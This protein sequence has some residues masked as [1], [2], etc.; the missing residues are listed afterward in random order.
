MSEPLTVSCC[1]SSVPDTQ[2]SWPK[3]GRV[4]M[5]TMLHSL[6]FEL[7]MVI[8]LGDNAVDTN[9]LKRVSLLALDHYLQ[10]CAVQLSGGPR[11]GRRGWV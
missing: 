8:L 9:E 7:V 11:R 1:L 3:S 2:A 10:R 4:D 5:T 6:V